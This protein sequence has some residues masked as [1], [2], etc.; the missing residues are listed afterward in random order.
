LGGLIFSD[1]SQK[2]ATLKLQVEPGG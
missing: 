1:L 2:T